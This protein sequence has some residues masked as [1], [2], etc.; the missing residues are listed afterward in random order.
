MDLF[1]EALDKY[2]NETYPE[3]YGKFVIVFHGPFVNYYFVFLWD[4]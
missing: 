3:H 2:L 4:R 1:T